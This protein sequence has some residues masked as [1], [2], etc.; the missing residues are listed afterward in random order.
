MQRAAAR[1][2][3]NLGLGE[4]LPRHDVLL[5]RG[6]QEST[7]DLT[8]RAYLGRAPGFLYGDASL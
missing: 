4:K 3:A 8:V 5:L 1:C 2:F 6:L 7:E